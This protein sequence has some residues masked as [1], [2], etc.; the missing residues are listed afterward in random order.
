M[1]M[2]YGVLGNEGT[3]RVKESEALKVEEGKTT[4][5]ILDEVQ[6]FG[7]TRKRTF[8]STT[9][10]GKIWGDLG[11][12]GRGVKAGGNQAGLRVERGNAK[13]GTSFSSC[14]KALSHFWGRV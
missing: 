3:P 8:R 9:A 14:H 7:G 2:P 6:N 11:K 4:V 13:N 1:H 12:G 10:G 5:W